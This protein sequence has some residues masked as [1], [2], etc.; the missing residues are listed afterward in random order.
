MPTGGATLAEDRGNLLRAALLEAGLDEP[1]R[2]GTD[3]AAEFGVS[4]IWVRKL[5]AR[6]KVERDGEPDLPRRRSNRRMSAA[7]AWSHDS[8]RPSSRHG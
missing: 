7:I 6:L 4:S 5:R 3:I 8:G 2:S 1:T